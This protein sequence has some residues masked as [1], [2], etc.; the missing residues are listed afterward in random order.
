MTVTTV[1]WSLD[2]YHRMIAVGILADRRVELLNGEIVEMAI[3]GEPHAYSRNE[4][5]EYLT[6]VLGSRAKVRQDS[7]I[8][9]PNDSE[10]EP[11]IAIVQRLG[12]EY[13]SHHPYPEN[14]FWLIEYA[15]SSLEKDL[16]VKSKIYAEAGIPEYWVVNLKAMQLIVFRDPQNGAYASQQTLISGTINPLAFP[17]LA[18]V[19]EAILNP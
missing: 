10:P 5:D 9:L 17:D 19:V 3:E 11:D 15:E 1:K 4:A 2:D 6:E 14:I 8:T 12:R 13:R 16:D 18:I 7:P